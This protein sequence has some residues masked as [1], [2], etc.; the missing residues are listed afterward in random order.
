MIEYRIKYKKNSF[1]S[2]LA[3]IHKIV[4]S[5]SSWKESNQIKRTTCRIACMSEVLRMSRNERVYVTRILKNVL[6]Y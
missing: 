6:I 2:N 4:L 5:T 3:K 1:H